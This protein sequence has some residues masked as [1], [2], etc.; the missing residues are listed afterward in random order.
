MKEKD[1]LMHVFWIWEHNVSALEINIT[2]FKDYENDEKFIPS[3]IH[4][5]WHIIFSEDDIWEFFEE[6]GWI[7]QN[8][9]DYVSSYAM[10][11]WIEE[12]MAETFSA[13]VLD[14]NLDYS[15][16]SEILKS[17]FEFFNSRTKFRVMK[18]KI[19]MRMKISWIIN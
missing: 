11:W 12:D 4:E 6:F 17:K 3:L 19:K 1:T 9:F 15:W 18:R 14:D 16:M 2:Y 5:V 13:Y 10:R 7:Y 8:L